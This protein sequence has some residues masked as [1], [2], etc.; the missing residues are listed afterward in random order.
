MEM[1]G[2][3]ET[4]DRKIQRVNMSVNDRKYRKRSDGDEFNKG[5]DCDNHIDDDSD[6]V[7]ISMTMTKIKKS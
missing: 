1:R 7:M 6:D 5:V 3:C 2:F 4:S